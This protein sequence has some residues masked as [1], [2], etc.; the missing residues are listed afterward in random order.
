MGRKLSLFE[1]GDFNWLV[2]FFLVH[3]MIPKVCENKGKHRDFLQ[4]VVFAIFKHRMLFLKLPT[5]KRK[6]FLVLGR[7][8]RKWKPSPAPKRQDSSSPPS[9]RK[10][11]LVPWKCFCCWTFFIKFIANPT[12]NECKRWSVKNMPFEQE[13]GIHK[14]QT[15]VTDFYSPENII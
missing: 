7:G 13:G 8:R 11:I 9:V 15:T 1:N 4:N 12:L 6:V 2:V 14:S 5:T 3:I 10:C